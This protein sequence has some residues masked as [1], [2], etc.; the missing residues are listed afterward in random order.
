MT[1]R[2]ILFSG[3]MVRALLADTKTQTRRVFKV[4]GPMG[5]K[6]SI[7]SP[8]EEIVRLDD[9]SFHY[10]STSAMSGP[11]PCPYGIPG[12]R[13]WVREGFRIEQRGNRATGEKFD[14][15][16]YRADARMRPEFDPLRYKPSIHMP[17]AASRITLQIVDV[18]VE[19]LQEISE[20]DAKAEGAEPAQ[21]CHAHYHG[22]HL[23]WESINGP[24]SWDLN[25]WVWVVA[26]NRIT[27]N[28]RGEPAK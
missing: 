15:Y 1:A 4:T 16:V 28:S 6:C 27:P 20:H 9:G 11:Y 23:L 8:E 5:N 22:Y 18:R 13:L 19:R 2:P 17:R 12:D 7:T 24:G 3:P 10:L 14:V 25:P 21:C 26:F